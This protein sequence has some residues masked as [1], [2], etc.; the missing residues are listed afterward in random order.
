MWL[1]TDS[2]TALVFEGSI[3]SSRNQY[4]D[5]KPYDI[6]HSM[7]IINFDKDRIKAGMK[8]N[9]NLIFFLNG[10]RAKLIYEQIDV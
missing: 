9:A 5:F 10:I 1:E 4:L 3:I 8:V 2:Y 6:Q 7:R